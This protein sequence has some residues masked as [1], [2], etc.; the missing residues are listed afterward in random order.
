MYRILP[1]SR[2]AQ[3]FTAACQAEG[4]E[5]RYE[6][7]LGGSDA[8]HFNQ[9]GLVCLNIGLEMNNIHSSD[10][11]MRPSQLIQAVRLLERMI[12]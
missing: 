7:S 4:C 11:Y 8:N 9:K 5:A 12:A 10:E 1:D 3:L 6:Q 2:P